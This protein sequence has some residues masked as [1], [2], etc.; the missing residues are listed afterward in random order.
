MA[1]HSISSGTKVKLHAYTPWAQ[2]GCW[3]FGFN[4]IIFGCLKLPSQQHFPAEPPLL[5]ALLA[6]MTLNDNHMICECQLPVQKLQNLNFH[7]L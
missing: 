5:D 4:V 1:M 3:A 2:E 7:V 6:C